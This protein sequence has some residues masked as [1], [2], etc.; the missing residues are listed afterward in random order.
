MEVELETIEVEEA[1]FEGMTTAEAHW[2]ME[3][4][5]YVGLGEVGLEQARRLLIE[6]DKAMM[7]TASDPQFKSLFY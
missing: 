6:H 7:R 4:N 5:C 3:E 2:A 1:E